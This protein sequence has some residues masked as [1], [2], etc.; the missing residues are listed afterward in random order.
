MSGG[1]Q[2]GV[3]ALESPDIYLS[4]TIDSEVVND[5]HATADAAVPAGFASL[6]PAERSIRNLEITKATTFLALFASCQ[7]SRYPR[8]RQAKKRICFC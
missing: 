8:F 4:T 6:P 2:A 7:L 1:R 5:R 3:F